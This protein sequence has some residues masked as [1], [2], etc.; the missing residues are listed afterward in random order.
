MTVNLLA[1]F[2]TYERDMVRER[3][4]DKMTATRKRGMWVGGRPVLG[5]DLAD[6]QLIVNEEEAERV[7]EIFALYRGLGSVLAVLAELRRRGWHNKT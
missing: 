3:T 1:T 6:K 7:R 5:Y 4:R 2:A